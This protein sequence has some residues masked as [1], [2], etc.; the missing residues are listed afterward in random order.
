MVIKTR[1]IPEKEYAT[2]EEMFAD[3]KANMEE[4]LAIKKAQI[5]KSC[6]KGISVNCRPLEIGKYAEQN[7]AI[8]LDDNY[9]YIAVN[10]TLILDSHED[11]HDDNIWNKSA[12]EQQFK[13][14]LVEDHDLC[15]G[16]TIVR[17]ENIEIL[18]LKLPF[19]ALGFNY[20]G[21]TQALVYKFPKDKVTKD[22]VKEWLDSGDSI[23][24]SVRMQ[25]ITILFA[26]DSNNPDDKA[27]KKTYDDYVGKIANISDF[28]YVPYFFVI[29]EAKNVLESSLVIR[30]SNHV[31]GNLTNSKVEKSKEDYEKEIAELKSQLAIN[32]EIKEGAEQITPT[33]IATEE[34]TKVTQE[35][36]TKTDDTVVIEEKSNVNYTELAKSILQLKNN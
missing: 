6:E 24:A 14:Y 12:K 1:Y 26:M 21:N 19:T 23:E 16:K 20:P 17:K 31:T 10:T 5:Q 35:G 2:K 22:Y 25:Y 4:I 30:G 29:K 8:K 11:L 13:N 27:F 36:A 33:E 3:L 9:Y 32:E 28:E 18:I 7:K 34:P 15:I